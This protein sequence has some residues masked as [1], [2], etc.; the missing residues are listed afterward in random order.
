MTAQQAAPA[1][2]GSQKRS[3]ARVRAS[4]S[5]SA[6]AVA[7]HTGKSRIPINIFS[8]FGMRAELAFPPREARIF[9]PPGDSCVKLFA[10]SKRAC[11]GCAWEMRFNLCQFWV[12]FFFCHYRERPEELPLPM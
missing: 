11:P 4:T 1:S 12:T 7:R 3:A 9:S 2:N 5:H 6:R 10:C 8:H